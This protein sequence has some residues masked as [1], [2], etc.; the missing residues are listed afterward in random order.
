MENYLRLR[1]EE[2]DMEFKHKKA[3]PHMRSKRP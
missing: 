1:D 2:M 3:P